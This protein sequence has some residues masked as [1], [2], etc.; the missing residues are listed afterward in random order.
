MRYDATFY[1]PGFYDALALRVGVEVTGS[2]G[3][4]RITRAEAFDVFEDWRDSG[5]ATTD[6]TVGDMNRAALHRLLDA[7]IDGEEFEG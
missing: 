7:W 5:L 2:L 4:L 6:G 3:E 1:A